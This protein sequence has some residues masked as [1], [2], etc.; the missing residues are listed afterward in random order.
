MQFPAGVP[1]GEFL[2]LCDLRSVAT[3]RL[4]TE[5]PGAEVTEFDLFFLAEVLFGFLDSS[6]LCGNSK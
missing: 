1:L 4:V 3:A 6:G 2:G 5:E